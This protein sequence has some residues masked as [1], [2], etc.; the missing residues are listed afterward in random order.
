M[1]ILKYIPFDIARKFHLEKQRIFTLVN[2][3]QSP[4]RAT[5]IK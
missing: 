4:E 1:L 5:N 2:H 3:F